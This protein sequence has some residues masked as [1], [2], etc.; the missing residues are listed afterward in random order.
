MPTAQVLQ[1]LAE[2]VINPLLKLDPQSHQRLHQ[3]RGKRLIVWL[4]EVQWPIELAF[5]GD[6]SIHEAQVSWAE[7][8]E[9]N[10]PNECLIKTSISTMPELRDTRKITQ[11]IREEKL[12]LSGDM[13]IAQHVSALFQELD[14]D[15]EEVLSE[16]L[17]DIAAHQLVKTAKS[18]DQFAR[19]QLQQFAETLGTALIDEKRLAA[20]R[21]QVMHFGDQ[22]SQLRDDVDRLAARITQLENKKAP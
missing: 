6:I 2:T 8:L 4:D 22:V 9:R 7:A 21:L 17:G 16:H 5:E 1:A 10:A 14:I 3:L 18:F 15:W 20:H 11:L 19:Q 13:H 12:D